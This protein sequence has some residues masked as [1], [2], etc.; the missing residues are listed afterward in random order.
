MLHQ[1]CAENLILGRKAG[2]VMTVLLFV[3]ALTL[4]LALRAQST[5]SD[6][7]APTAKLSFDAVSIKTDKDPNVK[8]AG[9]VPRQSNGGLLHVTKGSVMDL[10]SGTYNF[11]GYEYRAVAVQLPQWA[12]SERFDIE[13]RATGNPT[14]DQMRLMVQSLLTDRF[15][16]AM[17]YEDRR[18]PFYALELVKPG[19][20]G[21]QIRG[22]TSSEE[23]CATDWVH[24]QLLTD[25]F[26]AA[27]G[28]P[29]RLQPT[30]SGLTRFGFRNVTMEQLA[31]FTTGMGE[32]DR[33]VL[34][35]TGLSGTFDLIIEYDRS[36]NNALQTETTVPNG[37]TLFEA[38]QKQLGLKLEEQTGPVK[39]FVVD[40]IEEPTPN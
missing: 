31:A 14:P 11:S 32:L 20:L 19:K 17:H 35:H 2:S 13:A 15:K 39:T 34:D 3:S 30:Q 36:A 23:A 27:C 22:Y 9:G 38:M 16:F 5:G 28:L 6:Q 1:R 33:P 7:T 26:P 40:H 25:G 8:P 21:P 37:P 29:Q 24:V 4:A 12:L 10:I 18:I